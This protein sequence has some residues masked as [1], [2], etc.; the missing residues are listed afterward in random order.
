MRRFHWITAVLAIAGTCAI[1]APA[2]SADG[3]PSP[4]VAV[5]WDGVAATGGAFR[6]VTLPARRGTVVAKV[7]VHGGRVVSWRTLR[8]GYGVPLVAFDGAGGGLSHD[9]RSLVLAESLRPRAA[10]APSTRFLVLGTRNLRIGHTIT[11]PGAFSFDALSADGKTLFLIQ[12]VSA[13]DLSRYVVRAYDI[14][15]GY[16]HPER[17]VDREEAW[18]RSMQGIPMTRATSSDGRWVYTLYQNPGVY[19]FIHALDTERRE[20]V[21]IDLP[22]R[23]AQNSLWKLKLRFADGGDSLEL[24][25]PRA[26]RAAIV[27]TGT[28]HV[29]AAR[30][31]AGR[32]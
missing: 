12:H 17:I 13:Q 21:C 18:E 15:G 19:A 32:L 20:A 11:L 27:D 29:R 23:R 7:R 26:R 3:G 5:G 2:A 10:L 22:W 6:Y 1:A 31:P 24:V 28:F 14:D 4:G 16:L 25:G 30:T 9:G 8:A